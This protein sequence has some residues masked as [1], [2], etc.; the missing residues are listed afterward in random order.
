M[1][2]TTKLLIGIALTFLF[3][4]SIGT[5][6]PTQNQENINTYCKENSQAVPVGFIHQNNQA[7]WIYTCQL[8]QGDNVPK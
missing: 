3:L 1:D 4:S 5:S 2:S 8:K 6:E 7:I